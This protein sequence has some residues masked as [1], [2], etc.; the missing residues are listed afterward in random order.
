MGESTSSSTSSSNSSS[1]AG[2]V[3]LVVVFNHNFEK[4]LPILD[5][6][7]AGRFS[8]VRYIMPFYEGERRDVIPV[9]DSSYVFQSYFVQAY[10]R[11]MAEGFGSFF[12]I[13]DDVL[14]NPRLTEHNVLAEL[15][16]TDRPYIR[17]FKPIWE[18]PWFWWHTIPALRAFKRERY[19][20]FHKHLP[21]REEFEAAF[22]R[23]GI[24]PRAMSRRELLP[25]LW[26]DVRKERKPV[27]LD[28]LI[29]WMWHAGGRTPQYPLVYSYSDVFVMPA[30]RYG[31][32]RHLCGIFTSMNLFV[33]IAVPTA[34]MLC[35]PQVTL[36]RDTKWRGVEALGNRDREDLFARYDFN[37]Q[38]VMDSMDERTTYLHPIKLSQLKN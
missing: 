17:E 14:L 7:Y 23:N 31:A 33:E 26:W 34:M 21:P 19:V 38:A 32:F 1:T 27:F 15:N 4:N 30:D 22:R 37:L 11:L 16:A 5:R 25:H 18:M 13:G 10:D 36:E 28:N 29:Y 20:E 9:Y 6:L 2:A 24:E 8:H 12:F 35:A 3:C